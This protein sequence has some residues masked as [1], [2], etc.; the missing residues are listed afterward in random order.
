MKLASWLNDLPNLDG[1]F[2]YKVNLFFFLKEIIGFQ[3]ANDNNRL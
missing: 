2:N 1:L 3:V